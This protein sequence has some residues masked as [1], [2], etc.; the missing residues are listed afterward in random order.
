[1]RPRLRADVR[2]VKSSEGVYVR[3][4]A[5]A[6]TLTGGAAYE[7]LDRLAPF[8]T[9]EHALDDLVAPLKSEQR[10]V[11]E[12]L[13]R[14]LLDQQLL[15][16]AR[17]D[18]PHS[19]T[20]EEQRV[21]APEIAFLRY[22]TDSAEHRFERLRSARVA[23]VG[24]GPVL[25]A[26]LEAGLRSGWRRVEVCTDDVV[27]PGAVRDSAQEVVVHTGPPSDP[28]LLLCVSDR[29]MELDAKAVGL[30]LVGGAEAW[31]TAVGPPE[32]VVACTRRLG[33]LHDSDEDLL[34]GPVPGIIAAHVALSCFRHLTGTAAE[35]PVL[36]RIDLRDLS[37][38]THRP[39][40]YAFTEPVRTDAVADTDRVDERLVDER[41]GV[42]RALDED[43]LPQVPLA[44]C[45]ATVSD[46]E[47]VLPGWAPLPQ[48]VGWGVDRDRARWH[49][50]LAALATYGSLVDRG[51]ERVD[52][53]TG[54]PCAMPAVNAQ[55]P[56]RAP[57]GVA[58][59]RSWGDAVAAGLRAHCEA[60]VSRS[61]EPGRPCDPET[62]VR[63]SGDERTVELLRLLRAA[64][65]PVEV[66]DQGDVLGVPAFVFRVAGESVVTCAATAVE[67]LRDGLERVLLRRQCGP[68]AVI[69][70]W[71]AEGD[72]LPAADDPRCRSL[73]TALR[74]AGRTVVAVPLV[75]DDAVRERVPCLVR[76]VVGDD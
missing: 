39:L 73:A 42:L 34:T 53:L 50:A 30:V 1:M 8:L 69:T 56:Y 41:V 24:H 23:L 40:P 27:P 18:E 47:A 38:R 76:V 63:S 22:A 26:L 36:T 16:D 13:V 71:V 32:R 14:S 65:V 64:D 25:A 68:Q 43:D 61:D 28:D 17:D 60:L 51:G 67:A 2:Y 11:V 49:T 57:V 46:P 44:V 4:S 59:G 45:R 55:A 15:V 62:V 21:Y 48:V 5:G 37:A 66:A 6:C 29:P 35:E 10:D 33:S 58:A 74:R 72:G 31:V 9:G 19:L 70:R 54:R 20:E 7:W 12:H 75:A 52:L 3:G